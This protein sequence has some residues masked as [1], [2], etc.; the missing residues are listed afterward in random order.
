MELSIKNFTLRPI[1]CPN[2]GVKVYDSKFHKDSG[3]VT[4]RCRYF[5]LDENAS[6]SDQ[7]I[8]TMNAYDFIKSF[9]YC[10][11]S[12]LITN[13]KFCR[14]LPLQNILKDGQVKNDLEG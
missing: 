12:H 10:T 5:S 6:L 4:V 7:D 14:W 1:D 13:W 2:V 3:Q 9:E 11:N 8:I